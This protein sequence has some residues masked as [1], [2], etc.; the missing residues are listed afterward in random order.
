MSCIRF[1]SLCALLCFIGIVA[2]PARAQIVRSGA[3]A[4]VTAAADGS[5]LAQAVATLSGPDGLQ[6]VV[7]TPPDGTFTMLD[8][9]SGTNALAASA[10]GFKTSTR[11]SV[12]VAIGRTTQ[13]TLT[14]AVA[15]SAETVNVTAGQ[16]AFDTT[17]T[18]SVIN[19]DRDRVQ[20]LPIPNRNYLTFVALSPQ[21]TPANPVLSQQTLT[22]SGD[23]F[24]FGGL[25]P[26]S[27]AVNLDGVGDDDEFGGSSRTQLSPEAINDF[28]I[29]NHG[30]SAAS[31]GAA[32][33]SIDVQTRA[34]LNHPHSDAF[35]FGQ[36]GILNGTLPLGLNPYKPDQSRLR[37]GVALGGAIQ[38]DKTFYYLAAEQELARGEDTNDLKPAAVSQIN[39]AI[40]QSDSLKGLT[41]QTGFFPATDQETELSGRIDRVLSARQSAMLRYA[42]TNTRNV[43]DAFNTGELAD[44][45]A[46][47][48]SFTSDNSVNGTLTSTV[49]TRLLNKF[50]FELS[51]RRTV[52]QTVSLSGP[53]VLIPGVALFGTPYAGNNRRFETHLEFAEGALLQRKHH[54]FQAGAGVDR[55]ALRSQVLDGSH[56]LFVFP[57]LAALTTGSADFYIRSFFNNPDTNFAEYRVNAYLQDHWTSARSLA[58]DYGLRYEDNHLPSILPQHPLNFSPRVG[59]AWTPLPSL[60]LRSG[61]GIFYDRYL[62]STHLWPDRKNSGKTPWL[63]HPISTLTCVFSR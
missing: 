11:S 44:R 60:V 4:G 63:L 15:G 43:A 42:F 50:S 34:G 17:Q 26:G 23:G 47:G 36:N 58:V 8:L 56:G 53:G 28:Q 40:R 5:P 9:P 41:L 54:L 20:E 32:G 27:N 14:L 24:G 33:G 3:I 49:S 46:R 29:I 48:S 57:S 59:V 30:F 19:I 55:V 10:S 35:L 39:A 45:A 2:V 31:G 16:S 13:L 12:S 61:F 37:A 22:Q 18:S 1:Q 62:L 38:H 6:R 25:R 52:E 21:A 51:Q 7:S